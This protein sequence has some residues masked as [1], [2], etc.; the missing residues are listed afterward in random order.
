M[1]SIS[2][3]HSASY[4]T[5]SVGAG[6]E[7]Y[8]TGAV[9]EGEPPGTWQ[10][11]GARQLGLAGQVDDAVMHAV[12]ARFADPTDPAFADPITRDQARLLGR[13]PK[14]FRTPEQVVQS[15]IESY[16]TEYGREP[17]PEQ[18][19]DWQ[20]DAERKAPK[21]VM[22][23]D[24]TYSVPKS[25]TV[26]WAAYSRAA[27]E[28]DTAGDTDTAQRMQAAADTI[29]A[30][31]ADANSVMLGHVEDQVVSR[32]GRHAA[33]RPGRWV[34]A[35]AVVVA[36]F[37][38][39]TSRERDPQL[40]THN[41]VLNRVVCPDGQWRA[42][43]G[44]ALYAAKHS[45]AAIASMEL[46]E[47]LTRDLGVG[48]VTREDGH[49][50]E[51]A[52]IDATEMALLS[53]RTRTT[54]E[55]AD[56]M[57]AAFEEAHGR[58]IT[59]YERDRL[60]QRAALL[61]RPVK[62]H[63]GETMAEM[64]DRADAVL[65]GEVA[66]GLANIAY[67]FDPFAAQASVEPTDDARAVAG[68]AESDSGRGAAL[69]APEPQRWSPDAV[70]DQAVAACHGP[71]GR[72]TFSRA[73]I[74]RQIA[75][76][77][78]PHLGLTA[79]G[80]GRALVEGLTDYALARDEVIQTAGLEV[81]DVPD[82]DRL[83]S[84]RAATIAPDAVRYAIRGQIAAEHA[85]LRAAGVRGRT[86][87]DPAAVT[88]WLDAHDQA[89]GEAGALTA[90]QREAVA[91][92]ASSDA[93]LAVLIGPAGTG[94]S[95]ALGRL[96]DAW[97][98]LTG[99]RVI[100]VATAQ[101]AAD[102]LRDDGLAVTANTAAFLA[103]QRR[104]AEGRPLP[105]DDTYRL[106]AG[107]VLAVDE[108]SMLDTATL[109][110]LHDHIADAVARMVL[111]G[112]PRQLGAVGAGG[113]MRTI[114]DD[115]AE[116]HTLGEVRRFT[117]DW[118]ARS[119]L[120]L[121]DGHLDAVTEYDRRG[122]L[123]A[124]GTQADTVTAVARAAAADRLAGR[125]SVVVTGS[126]VLAGEVSAAVRRH[127]VEAGVV[128]EGG[129]VLG[130]DGC[131]AGVGDLVQARRIDRGLGLTNRE[132]YVIIGV[133]EDG[134]LDVA[135]TRS[136]EVRVM[137]SD[138]LAADAALAY[139]GTAHATQGATVDT[140]H[141]VLVPGMALPSAYVGLTRGRTS[142]TAWAITD[143][144]IPHQP[145]QT[146]RGLLAAI[147]TGEDDPGELSAVDLARLD[148]ATRSSA[149]TLTTLIEDHTHLAC[150][151]RL[152]RDL[153]SLV[154]EGVLTEGQ[155]ARFASDQGTEHLTRQ[156]RALELAGHDPATVLR[157]AIDGRS[158]DGA[159]HSAQVVADR[160]NRTHGLPAPDLD[161]DDDHAVPAGIDAD[162][163]RYLSQLHQL[164]ADRAAELGEQAAAEAP[165]WAVAALGPVP[166]DDGSADA[167]GAWLAR[168]GQVAAYREATGWDH[169]EAAVGRC[170]GVHTPERRADWHHAYTA[171]GMPEDRRPEAELADGRL[172][173]RAAAAERVRTH[174][175]AYVDVDV[176]ARHQAAD[177]AEREA[178]LA[179]ST[180]RHE[181]ADRS[182][183]DAAAHRRAAAQLAEVAEERG[184]YLA[185]HAE[186]LATGDAALAELTR[187]G[188]IPGTEPDRTTAEEWLA[189][190]HDAR[191][192]DDHHRAITEYDLADQRD[193]TAESVA[194]QEIEAPSASPVSAVANSEAGDGLDDMATGAEITAA[195]TRAQ[196]TAGERADEESR[197]RHIAGDEGSTTADAAWTRYSTHSDESESE[198]RADGTDPGQQIADES[199][200]G[201]EA[202]AARAAE[203]ADLISD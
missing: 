64:L 54:T 181:D 34:D 55:A 145:T 187:R 132:T 133:R 20:L 155:R 148:E 38:Q 56:E 25:V 154:A 195:V 81:G 69:T 198:A 5:D 162:T 153:D 72:S 35:A 144:G 19:R 121:R 63:D 92:L 170:P 104:L 21:A 171:A 23:Y 11:R 68:V 50:F 196:A 84:G 147:T 105:G 95:Y 199:G 96:A 37:P 126:N 18:I 135:S 190:E 49:D 66:G 58:S 176:R 79:D 116:V 188:L 94:K 138:Y 40:H 203:T 193:D 29:E 76:A 9:A 45:A 10:G 172:R 4:L 101:V 151:L 108:A 61:T 51:V 1:L 150:R 74:A 32:V 189:A 180:G 16:T 106:T 13:A 12:Y 73:E 78:P 165:A 8:Y 182:A 22:F 186:T 167:R 185:H 158:L 42:I 202:V 48:W 197:D 143:A 124:G 75:L 168:A 120:Q 93:A 62:S 65:R 27:T 60:R 103:A 71:D 7:D 44:K 46:R 130:R 152:E 149:A 169:P 125:S 141:L 112:D 47:R 111:M 109:T 183:A 107:D 164:H 142:N 119:S 157:E 163:A 131:T 140:G 161:A 123:I 175:P 33:G 136:G 146:A 110:R 6:R 80:E 88:A 113:M 156:L 87:A 97:G 77:L 36:S 179:R 173:V 118:E 28:A 70:I 200:W 41:A 83:A 2:S 98:D 15:Q 59:S 115:G 82:A 139:A 194:A 177:A 53:S 137:P 129:V 90:A 174:A 3:G 99:G 26:L 184:R 102:V 100:G 166:D 17:T 85:L 201:D 52:G 39:H 122:R 192:A 134:G 57:I 91:A 128:T 114:V 160:I 24:L 159:R 117:Q 43:D 191:Q 30:A 178:A 31:I 14:Q 67:R 89:A 127:L 86:H